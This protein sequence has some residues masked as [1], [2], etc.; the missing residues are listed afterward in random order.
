MNK[1]YCSFKQIGRSK[2][3]FL[4]SYFNN[5]T[6]ETF[7]DIECTRSQ[8]GWRRNRSIGDIKMLLDGRFK[9]ETPIEDVIFLL[10][11][12]VLKESIKALFC[13]NIN[14]LV[15]FNKTRP[16][17]YFCDNPAIDAPRRTYKGTDGYS[18]VE[19]LEIHKNKTK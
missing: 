6:P 8:C 7:W 2:R 15:F 17:Y 5:N 4:L 10:V 12:L 11:D 18:W 9:K 13:P 3:D 16:Y 1:I 19:A 14:K